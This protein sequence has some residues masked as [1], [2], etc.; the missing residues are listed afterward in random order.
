MSSLKHIPRGIIY[1]KLGYDFKNIFRVL[2]AKLDDKKLI[3]N[4]KIHLQTITI[5]IFV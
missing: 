3:K 4:S 1:H 5:V 2:F